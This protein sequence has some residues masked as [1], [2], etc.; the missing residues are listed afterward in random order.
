M[1]ATPRKLFADVIL[2]VPVPKAY[3]YAV[4]ESME[5]LVTIGGR[6]VVQFGRK[7]LYSAVVVKLHP[8]APVEY[9]TK[10]IVSVLDTSPI[11]T[12]HQL[13][14]W[15][16]ISSY[17]MA[18]PGDVMKAALPAGMKLESETRIFL[19]G[20]NADHF[21]LDEQDYKVVQLVE[22]DRKSVV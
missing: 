13:M 6:V 12:S 9:E 2:P 16:W 21:D 17:Y 3:T 11:I 20:E 4:P 15:E 5:Q 14:L 22:A 7:K 19:T 18:F 10:D 1:S 8:N